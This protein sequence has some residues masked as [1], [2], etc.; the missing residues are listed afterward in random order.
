AVYAAESV[1]ERRVAHGMLC[2]G[3]ISTVLG[4]HLPG[5]GAVYISQSLR[6]LKPVYIGDTITALVEVAELFEEKNRVRFVTRCSNQ[7]AQLVA[8]GESLLM[9]RKA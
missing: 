4:T 8:E 6:F 9:P 5:P 3:F 1:F 7:D 2:A